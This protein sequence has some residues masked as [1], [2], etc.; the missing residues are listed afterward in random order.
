MAL[1]RQRAGGRPARIVILGNSKTANTTGKRAESWPSFMADYLTEN[2]LMASVDSWWGNANWGGGKDLKGGTLLGY[3]AY[4]PRVAWNPR[5][6]WQAKAALPGGP[7]GS[8]WLTT[9]SGATLKFTPSTKVDQCEIWHVEGDSL[10]GIAVQIA[11]GPIYRRK[12]IH[13]RLVSDA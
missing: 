13:Q 4:D 1:A 9:Q 12:K 3:D 2:G 11:G 7:G 6:G 10:G 8:P 5:A